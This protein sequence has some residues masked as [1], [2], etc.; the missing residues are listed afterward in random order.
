MIFLEVVFKI[1]CDSI[2]IF[3]KRFF[4]YFGWIMLIIFFIWIDVKVLVV[5]LFVLLSMLY[6]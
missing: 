1:E 3:V 4:F 6:R 2:I 5:V